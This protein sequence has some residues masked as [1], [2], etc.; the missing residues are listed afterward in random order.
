MH[1]PALPMPDRAGTAFAEAAS[2][3]HGAALSAWEEAI[4]AHVQQQM[5]LAVLR[6]S[7][8]APG[9]LDDAGPKYCNL[10]VAL[11][12]PTG[13]RLTFVASLELVE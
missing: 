4:R 12:L 7:Q 1:N 5:E 3:P 10:V 6:L 9:M 11:P 8:Q 13:E 2:H